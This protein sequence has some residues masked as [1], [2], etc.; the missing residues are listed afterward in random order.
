MKKSAN[1]NA[2]ISTV[3][4]VETANGNIHCAGLNPHLVSLDDEVR[5]NA[6]SDLM[7]EHPLFLKSLSATLA[8]HF[9]GEDGKGSLVE[10]I[11]WHQG[12]SLFIGADEAKLSAWA[13]GLFKAIH[14]QFELNEEFRI[15]E[16]A[17]DEDVQ[18]I[19]QCYFEYLANDAKANNPDAVL[20]IEEGDGAEEIQAISESAVEE[21]IAKVADA[22][23]TEDAAVAVDVV[24]SAQAIIE[25][26]NLPA[27]IEEQATGLVT[28]GQFGVFVSFMQKQAATNAKQ[29][30]LLSQLLNGMSE[31]QEQLA[32]ML[33]SIQAPVTAE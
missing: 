22:A 20:I 18:V 23:V 16:G 13:T 5:A 6:W 33:A 11:Q 17:T 27:A 15:P 31:Q 32:Q 7:K 12:P 9:M 14:E 8:E 1:L 24:E 26:A 25:G 29:L 3:F 28:S 4:F 21:A 19:G 30:G 2:I 10:I